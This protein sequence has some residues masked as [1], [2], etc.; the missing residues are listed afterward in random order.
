MGISGIRAWRASRFPRKN[1]DLGLK[2]LGFAGLEF[3]VGGFSIRVSGLEFRV[4][5]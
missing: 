5:I 1:R 3:R 4:F 2:A